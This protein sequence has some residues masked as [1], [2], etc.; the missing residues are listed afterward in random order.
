MAD[1]TPTEF[2]QGKYPGFGGVVSRT[3]A[4]SESWWPDRPQAPEGAPNVLLIMCDDLGFSDL[5]C[6]GGEIPTPN[7]DRL[8]A[9]GLRYTDFNVTPMCSPTRAAVLTGCNSHAV[10]VGHVAHSD[11][12]FPGYAAELSPDCLTIPEVLGASGYSSAMFGKWHLTKDSDCSSA[13]PKDSW[14][15]QRGFDRFYGILDGF[16]NLHHPHRLISDNSPVEVDE[17]PDDYFFTDDLTDQAIRWIR[18][19]G[20]SNPQKPWFMYFAHGAVHA[21]L[22]APRESIDDFE[23]KYSD[24]WDKLRETRL[25]RL[26][27][28]GIFP[29]DITLPP[30][31]SEEGN[32]VPAWDD[33]DDRQRELFAK[34][35]AV[36][37]AMVA[38]IDESL[39]RMRAALEQQ[40]VWDN[41]IVLF[42][43]DN[44]A[45][46]EGEEMGTASYYTHLMGADSW[47]S[48]YE[49]IDQIGGPQTMPHYPRGWAMACNTPFRLYKINTHAGGKR[50]PLI[51][52]W[53]KGELE[54]GSLRRQFVHCT[55][56]LPTLLDII[57]VERPATRRGVK[58][59][60]LAG[61]SAAQTLKGSQAESNHGAQYYE[62]WGHRGFQKGDWEACT[63]HQP[64]TE[65]SNEEWELYR[66]SDDPTQVRN[67]ASEHPEIVQELAAEWE[68]AAW[69]NRVYPLESGSMLKHVI[70][71]PKDIVWSEPVEI[72]PGTPTLERW[73]CLQ[74]I[75]ARD[76]EIEVEFAYADGD[77]GM[78]VAHGDQ[79]GGYC[80]YVSDG[81]LTFAHNDGRKM[82][83]V[84]GPK[85]EVGET[86][87][88]VSVSAPGGMIWNVEITVGGGSYSEIS[89]LDLFLAM[90]PFE[91]ID[92]GIDRRSPVDWDIFEVHGSFPYSGKLSRVGYKPGEFAPDSPVKLM[93]M[94]RDMGKKFD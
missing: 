71:P 57:G 13:G 81:A 89:G 22:H 82:R 70:R 72:A 17:Y 32:D 54:E 80:L 65:F 30:R 63:L 4:G 15:V 91:G 93:E 62:M 24:G 37:A 38:S 50:V 9:D 55:D 74:L 44:G 52:S 58:V 88:V 14:P 48:D 85:L 76:F 41:T 73:R 3:F 6:Y 7:L 39:G 12:G 60:E 11:P 25:G 83:R 27:E 36:Y 21:P 46:R 5:G 69:E 34:Y 2:K 68:K 20:A 78:L 79:G 51:V 40:G 8:A 29:E 23:G 59:Q 31:N 35:M 18:D 77:S 26:I 90:A 94:M 84:A 45:S 75:W 64:L 61:T 49:L 33:L 53:P 42:T 43:S 87:A 86:Q 56:I 92:V 47:E 1:A 66:R 67:L 16:T 10:G 28:L 19:H